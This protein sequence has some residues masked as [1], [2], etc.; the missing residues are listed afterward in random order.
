[1]RKR[2]QAPAGARACR[3]APDQYEKNNEAGCLSK[4]SNNT[5]SLSH[6][7]IK[8]GNLSLNIF[9]QSGP[10]VELVSGVVLP[11][12]EGRKS[13][14]L[15][16]AINFSIELWIAASDSKVSCISPEQSFGRRSV[17]KAGPSTPLKYAPLR[18]T[19]LLFDIKS[20]LRTLPIGKAGNR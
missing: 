3:V 7:L 4:A 12:C 5:Y 17:P 16:E 2:F 20:G 9:L 18:M 11:S 1:M 6:L 13:P 15:L 8:I 10:P 19:S 14:C